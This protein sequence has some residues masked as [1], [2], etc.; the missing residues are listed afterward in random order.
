M[1]HRQP[2][3]WGS[4]QVT[5]G[6]VFIER[7]RH[8]AQKSNGLAGHALHMDVLTALAKSKVSG[9]SGVSDQEDLYRIVHACPSPTW[10]PAAA[11][12]SL[13]KGVNLQIS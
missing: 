4:P 3:H 7:G 5:P 11:I 9:D 1:Y 13:I 10:K 2:K 6:F 8:Y 12:D